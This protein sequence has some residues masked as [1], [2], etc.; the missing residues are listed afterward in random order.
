MARCRSDCAIPTQ[1]A[2]AAHSCSAECGRYCQFPWSPHPNSALDEVRRA[3]PTAKFPSPNASQPPT[4]LDHGW[5]QA[6]PR[7]SRLKS[8]AL[9]PLGFPI[10]EPPKFQ[11]CWC[12][13]E[14]P[15]ASCG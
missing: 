9:A 13:P 12:E 1:K 15:E 4:V 7:F 6:L 5:P 14:P 3:L 2:D 11:G 8:L 10:H